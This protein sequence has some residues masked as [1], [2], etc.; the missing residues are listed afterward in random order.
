MLDELVKLMPPPAGLSFH[1][2]WKALS[3]A[4]LADLPSEYIDFVNLYGP[5]VFDEFL[6]VFVPGCENSNLDLI[7]QLDRQLAALR[8][9]RTDGNLHLRLPIFPEEGG[10]VP[11]GI[12]DNGDVCFWDTRPQSPDDWGVV[13]VD[14]RASDWL[15]HRG[16]M[17]DFLVHIFSQPHFCAVF[18]DDW[19]TDNPSFQKL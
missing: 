6:Y 4:G 11:W 5:G 1:G 9:L 16:G 15:E 2:D 3:T 19:P 12:T 7:R 18:P 10:I 14:G 13:V 8:E 17:S